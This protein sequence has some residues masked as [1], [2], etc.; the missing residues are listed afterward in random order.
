MTAPSAASP[1]HGAPHRADASIL[2]AILSPPP[3]VEYPNAASF[4]RA[5]ASAAPSMT[6]VDAAIVG[7]TL[8]DRLGYAFA[9]G[10]TAALHALVPALPR[11]GVAAL[12]ATEEGGAHP[13]A[14][15][16]TIVRDG[17]ACVLHGQKR[18]TTLGPEGAEILVVG[19][20][21]ESLTEARPRLAVVRVP[22]DAPGVTLEPLGAMPFIPEIPHASVR[23][24]GVRV[25]S[26]K[27]LPGDGYA[28]YLKPF[29][30][31]EDVHVHAAL[32]A[33]LGAIAVRARL[34]RAIVERIVTAVVTARGLAALDPTAPSVHIALAG[35][36]A[37]SRGIVGALDA[38]WDRVAE[39]TRSLFQRDR[40]LLGVASKARA[41]R[42]EAAWD[43]LTSGGSD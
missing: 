36:I 20:W 10:Y 32:F 42:R 4:F 29:R 11:G 27:V 9:G 34:D 40:S 28:D 12:A 30:T 1:S 3:A 24:D 21:A 6:P 43:A 23:L 17:D 39:P 5:L 14:I 25:P 26:S 35:L 8:V 31:V 13:R 33:F 16:T 2:D 7:G 15:K 22:S 18:W 37:E 19:A 41:A 38:V